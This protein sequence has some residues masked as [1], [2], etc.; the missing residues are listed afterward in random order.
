MVLAGDSLLFGKGRDPC[1]AQGDARETEMT[2]ARTLLPS[3]PRHLTVGLEGHIVCHI[4]IPHTDRYTL[5][6]VYALV[7]KNLAA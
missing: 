3:R 6:R 2:D 7:S 4:R 5:H 1:R